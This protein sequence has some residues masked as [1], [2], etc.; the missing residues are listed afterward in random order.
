TDLAILHDPNRPDNDRIF[1][2]VGSATNSGIV[3][4]DNIQWLRKF[5]DFCDQAAVPMELLG[6]RSMSKNPFSSLFIPGSG[7]TVDS[8][9]FQPFSQSDRTKIP[10]APTKRPNSVIYSVPVEGGL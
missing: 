5:R 3:G 1:F 8:G 2:G 10:A 7:E 4:L 6:L 9:P